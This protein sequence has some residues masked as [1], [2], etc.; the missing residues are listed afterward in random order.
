MADS[1]Q[2]VPTLNPSGNSRHV[3]YSLELQWTKCFIYDWKILIVMLCRS[4]VLRGKVQSNRNTWITGCGEN[5]GSNLLEETKV[6]HTP[7]TVNL[8]LTLQTTR[9]MFVWTVWTFRWTLFFLS[10]SSYSEWIMHQREKPGLHK[11]TRLCFHCLMFI[12]F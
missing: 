7:L 5:W 1:F 9:I 12:H 2:I 4:W 8:N 11:R 6:G 10:S 3:K